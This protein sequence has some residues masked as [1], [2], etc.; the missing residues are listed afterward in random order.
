MNQ[1]LFLRNK[2]KRQIL[3]NGKECTFTT[4]RLDKYK[5]L[6]VDSEIIV[7]GIYHE[8]ASHVIKTTSDAT[9]KR[10]SKIPM[11]LV[12]KDECTDNLKINDSI[13]V[14]GVAYRVTDITNLMDLNVAYD[15]SMEVID[16]GGST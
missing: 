12:L 11:L 8:Q 13:T 14:N 3:M 15:I 4:Y 10:K 1:A 2:I 9:I 7:Q 5:S 16:N 6:V